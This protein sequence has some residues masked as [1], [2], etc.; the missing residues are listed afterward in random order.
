MVNKALYPKYKWKISEEF[1]SEQSSSWHTEL[2]LSALLRNVLEN[3]GIYEAETAREFFRP[4]LSDL[5]DPFLFKGMD[6]AVNRLVSA[7]SAKEKVM[8]YG[9]YDV[10]G[11]TAVSMAYLFLSEI[12]F[13]VHYYIPDRYKEGYGVSEIAMN[14]AITEDFKLII[15]LDC[16]IRDFASIE[17]AANN[18][19]DVI[20]CDHHEPADTLP[21]AIAVLNPKQKDCSYPFDG[22]SGCGVGFKLLHAFCIQSDLDERLIFSCLD[23]VALST[24]ADIVPMLDENRALTYFG[25]KEMEQGCRP[26]IASLLKQANFEKI[27]L[28]VSDLVFTLAPRINAAGRMKHGALAVQLLSSLDF[29]ECAE[30]AAEIEDLNK[31]RRAD[32]KSITSQALAQLH[33][34]DDADNPATVV[35]GPKWNKGVIGIVASRL[36]EN[37]Y[38]PTIVLTGEDGTL[39][40]SARSVHGFDIQNGL[41]QCADVLEKHGGHAMA[42]G[43]TLKKSNLKAFKKKFSEVVRSELGEI[44]PQPEL[45]IDSQMD[46]DNFSIFDFKCLRRMEPY[47]PGNLNPLFV[48]RG[49]KMSRKSKIIGQDKTHLSF[50]VKSNRNFE[51][52][53]IGFGMAEAKAQIDKCEYFDLVFSI[54]MNHW[55]GKESIQ[56]QIRD[57]KTYPEH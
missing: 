20:V 41:E 10:D 11:T 15:T 40:G 6:I 42:A 46:L 52:S 8:I 50:A 39:T 4:K 9:D 7:L 13:D 12:G 47:G 25:L 18:A 32:D 30:L 5:H 29:E 23:L 37:Y 14:K 34:E 1:I 53:C 2:G 49:L 45:S 19:I 17:L 31:S 3:R 16:G 54:E 38:R 26:G 55:K 22:L 48:C 21:K 51:I 56:F 57:P 43:L 35:L 24:A 44:I 27:K 28:T 36:I 33:S